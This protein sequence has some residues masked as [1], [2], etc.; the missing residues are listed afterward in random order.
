[1]RD[2]LL[3]IYNNTLN[4]WKGLDKVQQRRLVMATAGLVVALG[5]TIFFAVRPTWVILES[6]LDFTTSSEIRQLLDDAGIPHRVSQGGRVIEIREQ[7][8]SDAM[9]EVRTNAS[10][11]TMGDRFLLQNVLDEINMSTSEDTRQEMFRRAQENQLAEDLTSIQGIEDANVTLVLADTR[12]AFLGT[13]ESSA[14]I[15]LTTSRQLTQ[16]E[17]LQLA[18]NIANSVESLSIE[19]V[20]ITDQNLQNI[21]NGAA[22]G[23]ERFGA[24]NSEQDARL[25]QT[26]LMEH[27][28]MS[29]FSPFFSDVRVSANVVINMTETTTVA[30]VFENPSDTGEGFITE[31]ERLEETAT[32]TAP[33]MPEPGVAANEGGFPFNLMGGAQGDTEATRTAVTETRVYNEINTTT[34]SPSGALNH[35]ESNLAV[36]LSNDIFV[37]QSTFEQQ[38]ILPEGVIGDDTMTWDMI[39]LSNQN[40]IPLLIDADLVSAAS[41]ATGIPEESITVMAFGNL[42]FIDAPQ[43]PIDFYSIILFVILVVL[44]ALLIYGLIRS[45]KTEEIIDVEPE[46]SVEDLLVSTRIEEAQIEQETQSL[47]EIAYSIDSEVK[48]QIDKFVHEKPEAVAQLIRSWMNEGWE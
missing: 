2:K 14:S 25:Q 24:N 4:K 34:I 5:V 44:L 27:R 11:F 47:Q 6:N 20:T 46:L 30:R 37:H 18:S 48:Q 3:N 15:I 23:D 17:S 16:Q 13:A 9:I 38:G 26:L 32:G 39:I 7:D 43:V 19:N 28:V 10:A 12:S 1:M 42:I 41:N 8:H 21:F 35:A 40:P 22:A 36:L 33:A 29:I 31:S 45:R